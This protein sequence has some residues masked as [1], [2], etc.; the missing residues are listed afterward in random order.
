MGQEARGREAKEEEKIRNKMDDTKYDNTAQPR[1]RSLRK[2]ET[3]NP[4]P[5]KAEDGELQKDNGQEEK[6]A[7]GICVSTYG[8]PANGTYRTNVCVCVCP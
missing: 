8:E 1:K 7:K 3:V 4:N 6:P 5:W 2:T